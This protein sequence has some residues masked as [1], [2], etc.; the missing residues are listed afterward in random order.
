MLQ[1]I[2][3]NQF[4]Q[5]YL[6][7][8]LKHQTQISFL[9]TASD[10][11]FYMQ[12]KEIYR[13]SDK[14]ARSFAVKYT[15]KTFTVTDTTTSESPREAGKNSQQY[16]SS[17]EKRCTVVFT[18]TGKYDF[19]LRFTPLVQRVSSAPMTHHSMVSYGGYP[20]VM[21]VE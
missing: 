20:S 21:N 10:V 16:T 14:I 17:F 12:N 18:W 5:L 19:T 13:S 15:D 8:Y 1:A 6:F 9:R 3:V 7:A 11:V 4:D 2:E